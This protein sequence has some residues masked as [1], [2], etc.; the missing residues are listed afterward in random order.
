MLRLICT[1]LCSKNVYLKVLRYDIRNF[2][3]SEHPSKIGALNHVAVA[4]NNLQ[5]AVDY[6][7]EALGATNHWEALVLF[8]NS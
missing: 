2:S 1:N 5:K 6:Y 8:L 4:V 3:S 7:R